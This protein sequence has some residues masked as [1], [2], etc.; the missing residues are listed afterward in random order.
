MDEAADL[1]NAPQL[2]EAR[3]AASV[4]NPVVLSFP[5]TEYVILETPDQLRLWERTWRE[6]FGLDVNADA[7]AAASKTL[8][9]CD[10][11]AF[12]DTDADEP[13]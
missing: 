12:D 9:T 7:S 4:P 6:K 1:A 13:F 8:S 10:A 3:R 5:A 11:G 2:K